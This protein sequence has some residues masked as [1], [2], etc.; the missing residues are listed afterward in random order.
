MAFDTIRSGYTVSEAEAQRGC[1]FIENT[2]PREV[3]QVYA[4]ILRTV[5]LVSLAEL[6]LKNTQ[7]AFT[8]NQTKSDSALESIRPSHNNRSSAKAHS[9]TSRQ[10]TT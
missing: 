3:A 7:N 10:S 5:K 2:A 6:N 1:L 8:A 4:N 9:I